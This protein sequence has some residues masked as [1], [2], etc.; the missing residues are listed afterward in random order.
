MSF[1]GVNNCDS[2]QILFLYN[3]QIAMHSWEKKESGFS[4]PYHCHRKLE[5][6][7]SLII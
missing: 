7:I 3:F 5:I 1:L 6:L 4:L 2:P